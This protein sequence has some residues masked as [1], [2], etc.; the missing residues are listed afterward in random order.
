[1]YAPELADDPR[2][3][4]LHGQTEIEMVS[5][6]PS[7]LVI[8]H[9]IFDHDGTLSTLRRGW[10]TV[11][12]PMMIRAV[13]GERYPS[14]DE[15]LLARVEKRVGEFIDKTTGIQTLVQMEG[16][17]G[18]VREFG[19][20]PAS[21]ILDAFHYKAIYLDALMERVRNRADKLRR[22]ELDVS[23][24]TVK[25]APAVLR[26]LQKAG[27][28][29]YL[30]SGTDEKDVVAEAGI[31]GYADAFEGRIYGAVGDSAVE[32]KKIVLDRI[33]SDIGQ[34][35][36]PRVVT[37]GDGPVEI[38]ET[39]KR[40]GIAVG[41]A[42]DEQCRYGLNPSKR[43]RLICAGAHLVVPDFSQAQD[44]LHLLGL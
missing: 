44:L 36:A 9:A 43:S 33:L 4:V 21:D 29:L 15:A 22:G 38:R 31:L 25:N 1:M 5:A 24:F 3:A 10:E 12:E 13:L 30:A 2:L 39:R 8:S 42:S 26:K 27:I 11:M 34:E 14:A 17:I 28:K 19:V 35:N 20:V 23:D 6:L 7:S 32:A 40:G 18:I 37:F 41:V 16:L